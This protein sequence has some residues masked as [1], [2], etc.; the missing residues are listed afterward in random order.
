MESLYARHG[1][2]HNGS[3]LECV[4]A[5][6]VS[7]C[8]P[9]GLSQGGVDPRAYGL[10]LT[11]PNRN[12]QE[13]ALTPGPCLTRPSPND[14]ADVRESWFHAPSPVTVALPNRLNSGINSVR[15]SAIGMRRCLNPS[16]SSAPG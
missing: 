11:P 7:H 14:H 13:G 12:G 9:P 16:E 3:C 4:G 1:Q 6:A 15:Q 2:W 10:C 5:V 8:A